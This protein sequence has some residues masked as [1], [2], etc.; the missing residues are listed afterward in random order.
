MAQLHFYL[1]N[2]TAGEIKRRA[3]AA[4][5][6]VSKYLAEL[7]TR[8]LNAGWPNGFFEEVVGGWKGEPLERP[9]QGLPEKRNGL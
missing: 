3:Q 1:P 5:K 4:G 2:A 6:T 8:E 7:V 9:D